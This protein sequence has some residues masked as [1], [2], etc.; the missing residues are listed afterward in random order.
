MIENKQNRGLIYNL[1]GLVDV[2][3]E[4]YGFS[5]LYY[6]VVA[7]PRLSVERE[8]TPTPALLQIYL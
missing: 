3:S 1:N 8:V 5:S 6:V 7:G 4:E 2:I